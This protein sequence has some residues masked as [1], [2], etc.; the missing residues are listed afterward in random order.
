[1]ESGGR[2]FATFTDITL[3][4]G[5]S[6]VTTVTLPVVPGSSA[7]DGGAVPSG[8]TPAPVLASTMRAEL[9]RDGDPAPYREVTLQGSA[10]P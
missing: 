2:P 5:G 10:P 7:S 4:P 1:M 8:A 6:W 3:D 9:Y